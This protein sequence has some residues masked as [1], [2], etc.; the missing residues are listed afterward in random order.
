MKISKNPETDTDINL[1]QFNQDQRS[2]IRSNSSQ[3]NPTQP[4]SHI[5]EN[6]GRREEANIRTYHTLP[7]FYRRKEPLH[8]EDLTKPS[9]IYLTLRLYFYFYHFYN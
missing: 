2:Q 9:N 7:S 1:L 8:K 5:I 4:Q 3:P 6:T